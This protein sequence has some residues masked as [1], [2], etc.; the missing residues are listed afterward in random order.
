[1]VALVVVERFELLVRLRHGVERFEHLQ[2]RLLGVELRFE[3]IG[4][5]LR[6]QRLVERLLGIERL[7]IQ[8][9][10]ELRLERIE[11]G[12]LRIELREQQ[13]QRIEQRVL[14]GLVERQ[15]ELVRRPQHAR[16]LH[17]VREGR[18]EQLPAQRLLRRLLLQ[19]QDERVPRARFVLSVGDAQGASRRAASASSLA[20]ARMRSS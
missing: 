19:H 18:H 8:L 6:V 10:V 20:H 1:M 5:E 17:R 16:E 15:H 7:G 12:Q 4:V 9:R 2:Q 13:Q 3:R 14:V 11:L